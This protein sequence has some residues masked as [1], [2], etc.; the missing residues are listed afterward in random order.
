MA[1]IDKTYGNKAQAEEIISYLNNVK[2]A[3]KAR[4]GYD[5]TNYIYEPEWDDWNQENAE[6]DPE[7]V[8]PITNFPQA[9]DC[10]LAQRNDLP[11]HLEE[12]MRFQYDT[13]FDEMR[14]AVGKGGMYDFEPWKYEV[15]T[16]FKIDWSDYK[17]WDKGFNHLDT[18]RDRLF[19]NAHYFGPDNKHQNYG[20]S[21]WFTE[22]KYFGNPAGWLCDS[23]EF[24]HYEG[25]TSSSADPEIH[26]LKALIRWCR[27]M[28]FPKG[29]V[30]DVS[31][32]YVGGDFK[33]YCK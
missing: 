16:K 14:N 22:G 11:P 1:G 31:T 21:L 15:A 27:K 29:T 19:I 17:L 20:T 32:N 25:W 8:H 33:I 18:G 3:I 12:E 6:Y 30:L 7:S 2:D 28:K 24:K 23:M 10:A 9:V 13:T 4:C 26:T 5:P